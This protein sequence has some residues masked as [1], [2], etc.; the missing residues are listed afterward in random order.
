MYHSIH[1]LIGYDGDKSIHQSENMYLST[2]ADDITEHTLFNFSKKN[3]WIKF[4]IY[5]I[6]KIEVIPVSDDAS[7]LIKIHFEIEI[8]YTNVLEILSSASDTSATKSWDISFFIG[9]GLGSAIH[10]RKAG[11]ILLYYTS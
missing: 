1:V 6:C 8:V 4:Q 2:Q 7:I 5:Y 3:I 10:N 11:T 9:V